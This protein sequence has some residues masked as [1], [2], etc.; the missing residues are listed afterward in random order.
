MVVLVVGAG[1]TGLTL[2]A[3][4]QALGTDVRII[5]RSDGPTRESRALAIQPRTLELLA[6]LGITD[7]LI[8]RGNPA[9]RVEVH[10]GHRT[11]ELPLFDIGADDTAYP[12]LLFLSQAETEDVLDDHLARCGLTVER[13]R[14]LIGLRTEPDHIVCTVRTGDGG[15]ETIKADYVVGCDGA[16]SAVRHHTG[17]AFTGRA[18]PQTFALADLDADGLEPGAAHAYLSD[19]GMLLFFPLVRPA[20]WRLLTMRPPP[21]QRSAHDDDRSPSQ[22]ELQA[23]ADAYTSNAVRLHDPVWATWFRIHLRHASAYRSDRVFLAGDA[24][25]VHSPAGA[26]GMNTGIQDAWNLGWKLAL[27]TDGTAPP[28]LL[29]TYQSERMPI[30][31]DVLRLT[32]R[33]FRIATSAHPVVRFARRHIAPRLLAVAAR[34]QRPRASGMRRLGQLD[35]TYRDSPAVHDGTPPLRRGRRAGDRLPDAPLHLDGIPSTLHKALAAPQHHLLLTGPTTAWPQQHLTTIT[36]RYHPIVRVHRLTRQPAPGCL[37]DPDGTA[38][39][40]LGIDHPDSTAHHLVRPD[41]HIAYRATGTNLTDLH[42]HIV[43]WLPGLP[44]QRH[45]Q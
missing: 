42:A 38:H 5:D 39:Q 24:A 32:D 37:H 20:A 22:T 33:A 44:K 35:I 16:R 36:E 7:Q 43:H 28:E 23:L 27:V 13:C 12:F 15:I 14:E 45:S 8:E 6:G 2:A 29:D 18:Y 4:L 31:R 41:G 26:Q 10:A 30:G 1:P 11:V 9:V 40:R 25:H 3:Q 17:I 21:E 19:A 34:S